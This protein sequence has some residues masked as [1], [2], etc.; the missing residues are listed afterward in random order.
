M[1]LEQAN[2]INQRTIEVITRQASLSRGFTGFTA[3]IISQATTAV[4]GLT[5]DMEA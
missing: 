1:Y 5:L 3:G 4:P 2:N